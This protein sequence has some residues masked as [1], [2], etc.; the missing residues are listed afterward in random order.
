MPLAGACAM[1]SFPAH[2]L[3]VAC[4]L[5]AG[6]WLIAYLLPPARNRLVDRAISFLLALLVVALLWAAYTR[7]TEGRAFWGLLAAG[8][9]LNVL[10]NVVWAV[11]HVRG[12]TKLPVLSV[13]DIAY[14]ARYGLVWMA[15]CSYPS[16]APAWHS[17]LLFAIAV[18]ASSALALYLGRARDPTSE[19]DAY[20]LGRGVYPLLD[21]LL[22]AA[23]AYVCL[24][25]TAATGR[26]VPGA[27]SLALVA[28]GVANWLNLRDRGYALENRE[29]RAALLWPLSDIL[30]GVAAVCA[31][32]PCC[33]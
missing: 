26:A 3:V 11:Y 23:G 28:Y 27:I 22:A 6:A 29:S 9:S 30:A 14:L 8:W 25:T 18:A 2:A 1:N 32:E 7:S 19:R 20:L 10:A 16:S 17:M 21:T 33:L 24:R 4:G 5:T 13:V 31:I 15:L 12:K